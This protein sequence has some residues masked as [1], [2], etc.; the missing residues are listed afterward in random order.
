MSGSSVE[1][2][3]PPPRESR[4]CTVRSGPRAPLSTVG[5]TASGSRPVA[6]CADALARV[7]SRRLGRRG[8]PQLV[9]TEPPAFSLGWETREQF[10]RLLTVVR[11]SRDE[12]ELISCVERLFVLRQQLRRGGL[13]VEQAILEKLSELRELGEAG[14]FFCECDQLGCTGRI[15]LPLREFAFVRG[16]TSLFVVLRGHEDREH[17]RVVTDHGS[18]LI[19]RTLPPGDG[20]DSGQGGSSSSHAPTARRQR[21]LGTQRPSRRLPAR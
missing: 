3:Q 19:V 4:E 13:L 15:R 17:E 18:Y 1:F 2:P 6:G 11:E 7:A 8:H 14:E 21:G 9:V 20:E 5:L 10:Q 16:S 12:A